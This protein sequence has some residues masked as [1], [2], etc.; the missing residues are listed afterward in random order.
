MST[1]AINV[2]H[3]AGQAGDCQLVAPALL[4][5]TGTILGIDEYPDGIF[6][7]YYPIPIAGNA[8]RNG[9]EL[10]FIVALMQQTTKCVSFHF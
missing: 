3:Y 5:I 8:Y 1:V 6:T 9:T 2:R 7:K 4:A 10:E